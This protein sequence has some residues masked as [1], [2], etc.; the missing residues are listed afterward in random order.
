MPRNY[1]KKATLTSKSDASETKKIVRDI[2]DDIEAGGDAK[3]LEYAAKFDR[4]TGEISCR[5]RPSKPRR[6]RCQTNCAEILS[7]RT[8]TSKSSPRHN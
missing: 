5:P 3:A 7:S 8:P 4:Y 2:L 1:L 6:R